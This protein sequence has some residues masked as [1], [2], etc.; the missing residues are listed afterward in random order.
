M[1]GKWLDYLRDA[2]RNKVP[3]AVALGGL[4]A[5]ITEWS[6]YHS[7]DV[8]LKLLFTNGLVLWIAAGDLFESP[9]KYPWYISILTIA[10][11]LSIVWISATLLSA[12]LRQ[13]L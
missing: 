4:V 1:R 8:F 11:W 2:I 6:N 12:Y 3:T 9:K 13:T 10:Y 5:F 7:F